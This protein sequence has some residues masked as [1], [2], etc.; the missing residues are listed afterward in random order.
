[1]DAGQKFR[2]KIWAFCLSVII[3]SLV[4]E[5]NHEER[6]RDLEYGRRMQHIRNRGQDV[7]NSETIDMLERFLRKLSETEK[8]NH[9]QFSSYP[10]GRPSDSERTQ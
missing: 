6:L 3:L 4:I 2:L 5:V 1:M 8:G 9:E 7:I 10:S